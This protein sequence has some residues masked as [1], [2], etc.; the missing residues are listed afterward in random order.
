MKMPIPNDPSNPYNP[1]FESIPNGGLRE[2]TTID[3]KVLHNAKIQ[4][5][6]NVLCP[7]QPPFYISKE[8]WDRLIAGEYENGIKWLPVDYEVYAFV[9][10]I[11]ETG[12]GYIEFPSPVYYFRI[13]T[14]IRLKTKLNSTIEWK[15]Q[16]PRKPRVIYGMPEVEISNIAFIK[17][18]D[19][20][21]PVSFQFIREGDNE[22]INQRNQDVKTW[23][24]GSGEGMYHVNGGLQKLV[25]LSVRDRYAN[26]THVEP[27][28]YSIK[29]AQEG[30]I[31][32][33]KRIEEVLKGSVGTKIEFALDFY[34]D[35]P[36][37]KAGYFQPIKFVFT[38]EPEFQFFPIPRIKQHQFNLIKSDSIGP[39]HV[40]DGLPCPAP[41]AC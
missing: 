29:S 10:C 35:A 24:H 27:E 2:F 34:E 18:N 5:F 39:T 4:N 26:P 13:R 22:Q 16:K 8:I 14:I 12:Y 9:F 25:K 23:K 33:K 38:I 40:T 20:G 31:F 15:P 28:F 17:L 3:E 41:P 21:Q 7:R 32:S 36:R 1:N 30:V 19:D 37:D 11:A 6:K